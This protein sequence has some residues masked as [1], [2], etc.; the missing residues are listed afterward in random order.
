MN[1][2]I[3]NLSSKGL[4]IVI[5]VIGV[6]LSG[7]IMS[8]GNPYGMS[9]EETDAI[10]LEIAKSENA[11]KQGLTQEQLNDYIEEKGIEEKNNL[12][13]QQGEKVATTLVFSQWIMY[14]AALLIVAALVIAIIGSPKQYVVGI[15]GVGVFVGLLAIIY[16][17]AGTDV[18][19]VLT[20]A[21]AEK[22]NPGDE[23]LF[24]GGNWKIAGASMISM[25]VLIVLAVVTIVGSEVYKLIKG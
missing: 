4:M 17:M 16:S 11:D 20:I 13:G 21:E 5:I 22:L 15:I 8:Y 1:D 18:P 6:V 7:L 12:L 3:I 2:K 19:E 10:G 9:K 25:M 14:I 24:T 23:G